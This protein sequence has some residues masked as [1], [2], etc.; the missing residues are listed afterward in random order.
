MLIMD[1][2]MFLKLAKIPV[3][4]LYKLKLLTCNRIKRIKILPSEKTVDLIIKEKLSISRFGDGEMN[5]MNGKDIGFQSYDPKLSVLLKKVIQKPIKEHL[6]CIPYSLVD[7]SEYTLKSEIFWKYSFI[8]NGK[9]WLS[10]LSYDKIYGDSLFSRFYVDMKDKSKID[11][12]VNNIKNIW[13]K[14]DLLIVEGAE[15]R[16]GVGNDLFENVNSIRRIL[17]PV[18]DSFSYYEC[19]K[20]EIQLYSKELL[21]LIALGPTAT[22][23]A[24]ELSQI[25]YQAIDIG[26]IDI[27]YEWYLRGTD[28]KI[29]IQGKYVNECHTTGGVIADKTYES[30]IDCIIP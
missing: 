7:L 10:V 12:T 1:K 5:L 3:F 11:K 29:P 30:Q 25:G 28:N 24:Y 27:E 26:H 23:L 8:M 22:V 14:R 6:V 16:L 18:K 20:D 2:M 19:I 4:V 15:S 21:I 13:S 17:C 9:K